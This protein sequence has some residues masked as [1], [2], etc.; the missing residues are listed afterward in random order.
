MLDVGLQAAESLVRARHFL[1]SRVFHQQALCAYDV[2]FADFLGQWLPRGKYPVA[3]SEHLKTD[4]DQV[5]AA[6]GEAARDPRA[7]GHDAA[8]RIV[9][10][11]PFQLVYH[12]RPRLAESRHFSGKAICEAAK[13]QF[14]PASVRWIVR[15]VKSGLLRFP[16]Q[17][18]DGSIALSTAISGPLACPPAGC[19]EYV[20]VDRSL[21][22]R[23]RRW[24]SERG[25]VIA[26]QE[27]GK[28]CTARSPSGLSI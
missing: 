6:C 5:A 20:F 22:D 25:E 2:H 10:H 12:G 18:R 27:R 13:R 19:V 23:A 1:F 21:A 16:V 11:E 15:T 24:V 9:S 26:A 4:D 3:V 14:G 17:L 7:P 28:T 8:R